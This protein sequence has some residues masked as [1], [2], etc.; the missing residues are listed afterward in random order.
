VVD[1]KIICAE[2]TVCTPEINGKIAMDIVIEYLPQRVYNIGK[3]IVMI[4]LFVLVVIGFLLRR[5]RV[6]RIL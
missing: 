3:I 5:R 1:P 6:S 4:S 2:N